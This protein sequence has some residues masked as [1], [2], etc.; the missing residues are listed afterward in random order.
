MFPPFDPD[1]DVVTL[2]RAL[3]GARLL[4]RGAGGLIIETEAYALDDPA[5]H[6]FRG[7]TPRNATMFG[8]AGHAYVYRSYGIHL[9]LNVVGRRGEAVLIRALAPD[10]GLEQMQARRGQGPLCAGPGRLAQALG[11]EPDDDGK[12]FDGRELQLIPFADTGPAL[13]RGPRIGISQA[14]ERPWRFGLA[15]AK[16]LSRPFPR[17]QG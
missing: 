8:P 10:A 16:G 7:L 15:G 13:W 12:A 11:I 6:S 1:L 9:C 5:S 2:A 3:I 4:V 14:Q 17:Q